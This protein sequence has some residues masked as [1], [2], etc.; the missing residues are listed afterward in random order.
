MVIAQL[1]L[2]TTL[3]QQ[4]TCTRSYEQVIR[5]GCRHECFEVACVCFKCLTE[6]TTDELG[7]LGT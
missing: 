3:F 2:L 7:V 6:S 5:E 4:R 1:Q